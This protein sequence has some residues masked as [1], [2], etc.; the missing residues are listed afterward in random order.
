MRS[1]QRGVTLPEL[2]VSLL[3]FAMISGVAVYALRL[4]VEG[5]DQLGL[6]DKS[7]RE[8]QIARIVIKEDLLQAAPRVTRDEFGNSNPGAFI[9]GKGLAFRTPKEGETVLMAFVRRGWE[10]PGDLAPRSTLQAVEYILIGDR[11]VRRTRPYLD[12]AAGQPRTDRTLVSGVE[13]AEVAFFLNETSAGI[14]WSDLWPS[15]QLSTPLP[16]GVKMTLTTKSLGAFEQLFYLREPV[17]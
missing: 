1:T 14:N 3:I 8:M 4:T 15:P 9:G 7:I 13:A 6:A 16:A 5:R 10:N 17:R 2:L 11:L 12:D